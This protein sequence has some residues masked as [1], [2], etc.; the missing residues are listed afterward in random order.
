MRGVLK[1]VVGVGKRMGLVGMGTSPSK[2]STQVFL[3]LGELKRLKARAE[4]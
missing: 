1:M 3:V 2:T 4:Q